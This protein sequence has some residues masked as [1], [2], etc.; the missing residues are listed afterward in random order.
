MQLIF[1]FSPNNGGENIDR[2]GCVRW[3]LREHLT[4]PCSD[5][6]SGGLEDHHQTN[7]KYLK[8]LYLMYTLNQIFLIFNLLP[9]LLLLLYK[10]L[11]DMIFQIICIYF[12][13]LS[14][15]FVKTKLYYFRRLQGDNLKRI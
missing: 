7:F 1:I 6:A 8:I 12:E 2:H 14:I 3:A 5:F 10:Y 4:P 9:L 15:F 13:I 11:G